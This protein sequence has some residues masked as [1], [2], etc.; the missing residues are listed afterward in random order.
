MRTHRTARRVQPAHDEPKTC[1][2]SPNRLRLA[3]TTYGC[4]EEPLRSHSC[5]CIQAQAGLFQDFPLMVIELPLLADDPP[6]LRAFQPQ[7]RRCLQ[8]S[9]PKFLLDRVSKKGARRHNV[10]PNLGVVES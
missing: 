6:I 1:A 7:I 5:H 2:G 3:G 10:V 9:P 8:F 4:S